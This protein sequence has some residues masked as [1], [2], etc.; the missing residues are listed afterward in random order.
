MTSSL[1]YF[2]DSQKVNCTYKAC[3]HEDA[4]SK[5]VLLGD[6][7]LLDKTEANKKGFSVLPSF[8]SDEFTNLREYVLKA[9][10]QHFDC[11]IT[12]EG[13]T[14]YI[15]SLKDNDFYAK[16]KSVYRQGF[17]V[18]NLEK[19][20]DKNITEKI[21]DLLGYKINPLTVDGKQSVLI[22]IVRPFKYDFNPPHR[23]IYLNHLRN[24]INC[25]IPISG[26]NQYSSLA[27]I[28]NSHTWSE[29]S[30]IRTEN[31]PIFN[32]RQFTVPAIISMA[33]G[34]KLRMFRPVVPYGSVLI[35]SLYYSW[36]S[37]NTSNDANKS[38]AEV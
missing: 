5:A 36:G 18:D 7:N 16:M 15:S 27:L 19:I 14:K 34:A 2:I 4:S 11:K 29:D 35:F 30:T 38:R 23:D 9:L 26:V 28:E 10:S 8:S 17:P 33:D 24:S 21:S 22:R 31:S 20:S 12:L 6:Q 13:V 37:I 25:F 32:H 3:I 1:K